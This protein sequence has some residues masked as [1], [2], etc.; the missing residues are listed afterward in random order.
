MFLDMQRFTNKKVLLII[1][2][3]LHNSSATFKL[4]F[5]SYIDQTTKFLI[6]IL[7]I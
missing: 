6:A 3:I 7:L 2:I 1:I 5:K 4:Q